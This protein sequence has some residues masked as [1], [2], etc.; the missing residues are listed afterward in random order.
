MTAFNGSIRFHAEQHPARLTS[1]SRNGLRGDA[2]ITLTRSDEDEILER[3]RASSVPLDE[4]C[5][6]CLG[7]TP[8]DKYA[9]HRKEQIENKVFHAKSRLDSTFK[10]LL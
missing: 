2:E 7:L 1:R 9:G 6:F 10:K 5:E 8:Y 4:L 3:M